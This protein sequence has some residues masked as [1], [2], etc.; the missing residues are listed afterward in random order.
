MYV[1][2]SAD[3]VFVIL[4]FIGFWEQKAGKIVKVLLLLI[5]HSENTKRLAPRERSGVLEVVI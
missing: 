2:V 5:A 1:E 4:P 3:V